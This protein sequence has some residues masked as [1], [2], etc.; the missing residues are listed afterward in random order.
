MI[1]KTVQGIFAILAIFI[2]R[3]FSVIAGDFSSDSIF[4]SVTAIAFNMFY[5]YLP[6]SL[7]ITAGHMIPNLT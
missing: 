7:E 4:F 3:D 5:F 2:L 1:K 6:N